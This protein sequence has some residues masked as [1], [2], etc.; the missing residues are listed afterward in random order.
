MNIPFLFTRPVP[1]EIGA[2]APKLSALD[3]EGARIDLG[4]VYERGLTLIYFY[5]KADTP[6]CTAQG[7]SLRDAFDGL[8]QE[9]LSI[10]GVS[11][12]RPEAQK[13]FREKYRLPYSLVAD[14]DGRVARAFGVPTIL[15]FTWRQS[16]LIRDARI[17]WVSRSAKTTQHA[18]EVREAIAKML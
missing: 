7:C 4:S 6:G 5:P 15:G 9:G 3:H 14:F 11:H 2:A 13:R 1:L 8:S 17:A 16:F 18:E 12:D 10:L